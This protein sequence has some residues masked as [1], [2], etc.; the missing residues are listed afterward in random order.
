MF[1]RRKTGGNK[2]RENPALSNR[3]VPEKKQDGPAAERD[4]LSL[5][6]RIFSLGHDREFVYDDDE[7][8]Q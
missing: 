2:Q 6:A 5:L 3:R 8:D 4:R 7:D 1:F